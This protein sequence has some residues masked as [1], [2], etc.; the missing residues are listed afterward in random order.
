MQ[1]ELLISTPRLLTV[2]CTR[3]SLGP[4]HQSTA[5]INER[6]S[7]VRSLIAHSSGTPFP[8]ESKTYSAQFTRSAQSSLY[9]DLPSPQ[10]SS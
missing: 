4:P 7:T 1:T 5:L 6:P 8:H 3:R 2:M 9:L 10:R